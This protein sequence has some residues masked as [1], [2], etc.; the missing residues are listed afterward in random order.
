MN[1][2]ERMRVMCEWRGR[3]R[4]QERGG[5]GEEWRGGGRVSVRCCHL[6]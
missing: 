2:G 5:I 3:D 6:L 4:E 1:R